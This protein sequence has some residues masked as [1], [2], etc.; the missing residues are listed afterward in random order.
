MTAE[1]TSATEPPAETPPHFRLF[2]DGV[3]DYAIFMLDPGGRVLSWNNGAERL[4]E[5]RAEEAIGQHFSRFFV[6]DDIRTGRPEEELREAEARGQVAAENWHVRKDGTRFWAS[7]VTTALRDERGSLHGFAKVMRDTTDR[8]QLEMELRRQADELA[9]ANRRKD[10]L[11]AMLSH[12]LRNPLAPVLNSVQLLRHAPSD[13]AVVQRAG[14]MIERQVRNMARLIDY[15][16]EVTRITRGKV[17]L[18]RERLELGAVI[19]LAADGVRPRMAD[20]NL[21]FV[22]TPPAAPVWLEADAARVNQVLTNLLDNAAKYTDPGGRVEL[23]AAREGGSAVLRVRDT[24]MGI[25]PELLPRVFDLF[26]QADRSLDRERGGLGLG[27]T[28]VKSLVA[29]HGGTIEARSEGPGRGTEFVVGLPALPE[30]YAPPPDPPTSAGSGANGL[31][32]LVVDDNVDTATSLAMLLDLQGHAVETA[33]DGAR[34]VEAARTRTYDVLLLDLGLPVVD[35]YEAARQIRALGGDPR[36]LLVAISGYGFDT[37][38]ARAR[39]AGFDHHLVKP[40]ELAAITAI[41]P[42]RARGD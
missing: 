15:L 28:L 12:E 21:E 19:R 36:P 25:S 30:A 38:R 40:V 14:V 22:M 3:K 13:P 34:A 35:G 1:P 20:R 8:K 33:H 24:G 4:F 23:V 18:H 2:L 10:E 6:P 9:E 7:E 17:S 37:D 32:V 31:R 16:L 27:L 11:L 41:L 5:Y 39:A 42:A 29:L 26:A